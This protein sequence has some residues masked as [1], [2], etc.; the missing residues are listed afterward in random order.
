[1]ECNC[2]YK[3]LAELG[4]FPDES[5]NGKYKDLPFMNTHYRCPKCKS[6]KKIKWLTPIDSIRYA[7]LF[8]EFCNGTICNQPHNKTRKNV[9]FITSNSNNRFV[10]Y[11]IS[12]PIC[13]YG[14]GSGILIKEYENLIK[15]VKEGKFILIQKDADTELNKLG[16]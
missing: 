10:G 3:G 9:E 13:H 12:C 2:G 14:H 11:S 5:C 8:G 15:E 4:N 6:N 16:L 1:M 7:L